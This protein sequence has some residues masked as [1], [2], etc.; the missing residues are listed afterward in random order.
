MNTNDTQSRALVWKALSEFYLDTKLD[1]ADYIRIAKVLSDSP[2][3]F[4]EIVEI[5]LHE[6]FPVLQSNLLDMT[7]VWSGFDEKWL[8]Y[9]CEKLFYERKNPMKRGIHRFKNLFLYWMRRRHF[10]EVRRYF[11]KT[12]PVSFTSID[13]AI[14][15]SEQ[16]ANKVSPG[17]RELILR[18]IHALKNIKTSLENVGTMKRQ[19][20]AFGKLI[21]DPWME[22]QVAYNELYEAWINFKEHYRASMNAMTVNERLHF[23]GLLEEFDKA[24]NSRSKL[25]SILTEAFVDQSDIRA[26]IRQRG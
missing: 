17:D 9:R 21:S 26:I 19:L 6:V 8:L 16:W 22:N 10:E 11:R 24:G 7:G 20:S 14:E 25:E 15:K 4:P 2:Y 13:T 18:Q 23:M 12:S 5:D 1:E 3:S